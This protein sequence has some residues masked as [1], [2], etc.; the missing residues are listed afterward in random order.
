[1][2]MAESKM[3]RAHFLKSEETQK[4]YTQPPPQGQQSTKIRVTANVDTVPINPHASTES[5]GS[6]PVDEK[7]VGKPRPNKKMKDILT[8]VYELNNEM[9]E[10]IYTNQTGHFPT[11]SSRG[12]QYLMVMIDMDSSHKYGA[13]EE[14]PLVLND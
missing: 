7:Q 2:A 14:P 6:S 3:V 13:N 11:K 4:G 8:Q 1:M 5:C 10:N 9:Q 12:N